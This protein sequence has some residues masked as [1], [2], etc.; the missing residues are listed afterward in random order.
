MGLLNIII[1]K[2]ILYLI[3]QFYT[4]VFKSFLT[5]RFLILRIAEEINAINLKVGS[6]SVAMT[7]LEAFL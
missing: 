6:K 3:K 7:L 1:F 4:Q 2:Y 5:Y